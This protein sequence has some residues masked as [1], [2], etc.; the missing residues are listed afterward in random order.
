[1]KDDDGNGQGDSQD[2]L[3]TWFLAM[4]EKEGIADRISTRATKVINGVF[5]V[6]PDV[7]EAEDD[8]DWIDFVSTVA[9][10]MAL[11]HAA[12]GVAKD[13]ERAAVGCTVA[14]S[15][16]KDFYAKMFGDDGD[17]EG[18]EADGDGGDGGEGAG[19]K[20]EAAKASAPA[21]AER[22]LRLVPGPS[23]VQ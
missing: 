5:Q 11:I 3:P 18:A 4:M 16:A 14:E 6:A 21:K 22:H 20:A 2:S 12:V 8:D 10:G 9:A 7:S 13:A 1:M 17:G 19:A 23:E 15:I